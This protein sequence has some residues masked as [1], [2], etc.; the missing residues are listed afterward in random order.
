MLHSS[1]IL[2]LI[3]LMKWDRSKAETDSEDNSSDLS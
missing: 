1:K 3:Q 2:Q